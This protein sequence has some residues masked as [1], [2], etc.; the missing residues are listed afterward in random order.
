MSDNVVIKD[1]IKHEMVSTERVK[2]FYNFKGYVRSNTCY[3]PTTRL[4]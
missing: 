4:C 3:K 2:A 1:L